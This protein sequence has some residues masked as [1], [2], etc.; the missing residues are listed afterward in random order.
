L[1]VRASDSARVAFGDLMIHDY[2]ADA[3]VSSSFAVI[4]VRPGAR[5]PM[6]RSERSDKYYFVVDGSVS[7]TLG[8][9]KHRLDKGD[10]CM[11]PQGTVFG[12][13]NDSVD[14]AVMILVHT[15]EFDLQ[16]ETILE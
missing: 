2:T 8:D 10:F 4:H 14:E 11:V 12:Y 3:G 16:C 6:A 5:H 13:E 15:P 7:F 9:E 1:I